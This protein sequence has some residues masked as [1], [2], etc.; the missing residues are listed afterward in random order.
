LTAVFAAL[1]LHAFKIV[2]S[3]HRVRT[4]VVSP[5][6]LIG[7]RWSVTQTAAAVFPERIRDVR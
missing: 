1:I 7:A 2:F 6:H 3:G 5:A 4:Y